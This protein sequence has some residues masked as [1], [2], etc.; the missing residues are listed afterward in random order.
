MVVLWFCLIGL[1]ELI[2]RT[3]LTELKEGFEILLAAAPGGI[4]TVYSSQN[5]SYLLGVATVAIAGHTCVLAWFLLRFGRKSSRP[6]RTRGSQV[7]S[8]SSPSA[9][10]RLAPPRRNPFSALVWK[11]F[12]ETGPLALVAVAGIL[13]M[14]GFVLWLY[15]A[16][17]FQESGGELLAG[18]TLGVGFSGDLGNG[19]RRLLGRPQA[20][21]QSVL[22]FA[23]S[24]CHPVVFRQILYWADGLGNHVWCI[25]SVGLRLAQ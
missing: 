20:G 19:H 11:Q 23:A 24:E 15:P 4:V 25:V 2:R 1:L 6:A 18:I 10:A 16:L 13:A 14:T 8:M 7:A 17:H 22:A 21:D 12:H 3:G 9:L 5:V